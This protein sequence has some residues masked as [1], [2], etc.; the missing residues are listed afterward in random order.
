MIVGSASHGALRREFTER[1]V[2]ALLADQSV[3]R[4]VPEGGRSAVSED[5][6][7]TVGKAEKLADAVAHLTYEVL[8]RGLTVRGA[9]Q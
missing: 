3:G 1:Q 6:L 2:L 7:V 8:D 5:H 4:D 9:K